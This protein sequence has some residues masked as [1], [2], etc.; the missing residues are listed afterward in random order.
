MTGYGRIIGELSKAYL[1]IS[2]GDSG[3]LGGDVCEKNEETSLV[4]G[5]KC[6]GGKWNEQ[7]KMKGDE[8]YAKGDRGRETIT[9]G[10]ARLHTQPLPAGLAGLRAAAASPRQSWH[11]FCIDPDSS[12]PCCPRSSATGLAPRQPRGTFLSPQKEASVGGFHA[13]TV[14][15]KPQRLVLIRHTKQSLRG[16]RL[17]LDC[18]READVMTSLRILYF[19]I[20]I[21]SRPAV[22]DP[23]RR[24]P[25]LCSLRL[26]DSCSWVVSVLSAHA[27]T[28]APAL[29]DSIRGW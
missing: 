28:A 15:L 3:S 1:D 12:L 10:L 7:A 9:L 24:L 2:R 27:A 22:A 8:S 16:W 25:R 26:C 29:P 21:S 20:Q 14:V 11:L 5:V 18:E 17:R 23:R 4:D 19:N 6:V 13:G